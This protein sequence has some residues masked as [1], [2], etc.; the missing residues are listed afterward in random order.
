MTVQDAMELLPFHYVRGAIMYGN[1]LAEIEIEN[2]EEQNPEAC[3]RGDDLPE[4]KDYSLNPHIPTELTDSVQR[5]AYVEIVEESAR[6][7][8]KE[9]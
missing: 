1:D 4:W 2:W 9:G 6:T 5:E 8:Y 7:R 3:D